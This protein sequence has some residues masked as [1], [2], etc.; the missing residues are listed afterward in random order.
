MAA[1]EKNAGL[2]NELTELRKELE[3]SKELAEAIKTAKLETVR[4]GRGHFQD[5]RNK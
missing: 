1:Q 5:F 4:R 3:A 2:E